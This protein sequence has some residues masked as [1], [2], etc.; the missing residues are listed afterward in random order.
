MAGNRALRTT[1]L[2]AVLAAVAGLLL[3]VGGPTCA[4]D[5]VETIVPLPE[6]QAADQ[7]KKVIEM[8]SDG[9]G[10]NH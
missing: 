6:P 5:E 7:P 10:F 1:I 3:A 4:Q 9:C 2:V 8:I